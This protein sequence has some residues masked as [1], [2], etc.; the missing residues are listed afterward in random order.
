MRSVDPAALTPAQRHALFTRLT[1]PR[2][3]AVISTAAGDGGA[4]VAPLGYC[5]PLRG[6]ESVVAVTVAAVRGA[7]DE[8]ELVRAAALASGELVANLTTADLAQHLRDL[9]RA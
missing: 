7:G 8:P 6:Q 9:D 1:L 5:V 4:L 3:I 2:A